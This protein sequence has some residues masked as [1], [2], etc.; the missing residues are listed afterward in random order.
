[1]RLVVPTLQLRE[2][3]LDPRAADAR[4]RR[5]PAM[6]AGPPPEPD[7]A[8]AQET[9][10]REPESCE[11]ILPGVV[12]RSRVPESTSAARRDRP[13]DDRLPLATLRARSAR[14]SAVCTPPVRARARR[15]S[16]SRVCDAAAPGRRIVDRQ[17]G[18]S[19]CLRSAA[20]PHVPVARRASTPRSTSQLRSTGVAPVPLASWMR[21]PRAS[22]SR[23]PRR[24][25][26]CE[27][28]PG[29]RPPAPRRAARRRFDRYLAVLPFGRAASTVGSQRTVVNTPAA[30]APAGLGVGDR[31]EPRSSTASST[32]SAAARGGGDLAR[33]PVRGPVP[34]CRGAAA[35]QRVEDEPRA[36]VH[37]RAVVELL[38][39]EEHRV[40]HAELLSHDRCLL[41]CGPD[42]D[43][44][45]DVPRHRCSPAEGSVVRQAG[46]DRR[47]RVVPA[48]EPGH[49]VFEREHADRRGP[50]LE[51]CARLRAEAA[52]A[53]GQHSAAGDRARR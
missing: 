28:R 13:V 29:R 20:R 4:R 34:R 42:R 16:A 50:E 12:S 51:Q 21:R 52:P 6:P 49:V 43:A 47:P 45:R 36:D 25:T 48:P 41:R 46:S 14:R 19:G 33:V 53:S 2:R 30:H 37:V 1:M 39:L 5:V 17:R 35:G 9:S 10:H 40:Q 32:C 3:Q 44:R 31:V 23:G 15:R 24:R 7:L 18:R 38:E 8:P 22:P 27:R 26:S 11:A